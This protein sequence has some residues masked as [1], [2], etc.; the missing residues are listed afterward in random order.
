[1]SH[2]SKN[3]MINRRWDGETS[4][5]IGTDSICLHGRHKKKCI[6]RNVYTVDSDPTMYPCL[7]ADVRNGGLYGIPSDSMD[8]IELDGIGIKYSDRGNI[9]NE[10]NRVKKQICYI[11]AIFLSVGSYRDR[12]TGKWMN[13]YGDEVFIKFSELGNYDPVSTFDIHIDRD[14]YP[15][16]YDSDKYGANKRI[17][18]TDGC[19]D[20]F[21]VTLM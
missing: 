8:S 19:T 11:D 2:N 12:N 14:G 3:Y 16:L 13:Y 10:I 1:M 7:V 5:I 6:N 18:L 17:K 9:V 20:R 4:L 21:R 15:I